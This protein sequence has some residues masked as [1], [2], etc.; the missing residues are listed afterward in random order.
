MSSF[1]LN[2][3]FRLQ[4]T[5]R[6]A[7]RWK[8]APKKPF[9]QGVPKMRGQ[10]ADYWVLGAGCGLRGQQKRKVKRKKENS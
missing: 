3:G 6:A 10:G 2:N 8:Q 4:K 5:N 7:R 1:R 9:Y